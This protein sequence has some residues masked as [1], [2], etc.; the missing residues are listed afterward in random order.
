MPR[1]KICQYTEINF[2]PTAGQDQLGDPTDIGAGCPFKFVPSHRQIKCFDVSIWEKWTVG[3]PDNDR[4]QYFEG[5]SL[6]WACE[7]R[8]LNNVRP[9]GNF[10]FLL[11]DTI[12][13]RVL[14]TSGD[15]WQA[16][17]LQSPTFCDRDSVP[18][19]RCLSLLNCQ[20]TRH[21]KGPFHLE[22]GQLSQVSDGTV[23]YWQRCQPL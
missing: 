5:I 6:M 16:Q 2:P 22:W 23:Q 3:R 12:V 10:L 8:S 4:G 13:L 14:S 19:I 1:G 7:D 18:L 11:V 9:N 21:R 15:N 17:C 20:F